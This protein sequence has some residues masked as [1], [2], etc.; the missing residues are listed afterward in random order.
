MRPCPPLPDRGRY[1]EQVEL[2]R[3]LLL[4]H[5]ANPPLEHEATARYGRAKTQ[6]CLLQTQRTG[7]MENRRWDWEG[8]WDLSAA[9][10]LPRQVR[11]FRTKIPGQRR[12]LSR[13]SAHSW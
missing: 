1:G 7:C 13:S 8:F 11:L 6:W 12:S 3:A 9:A 4:N 5:Q 10:A 2:L